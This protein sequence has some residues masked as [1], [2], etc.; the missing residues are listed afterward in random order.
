M[1]LSDFLSYLSTGLSALGIVV[2]SYGALKEAYLFFLRAFAG[3]L[4][5]PWCE[6]GNALV[7]GLE[8]LIA[9]SLVRFAGSLTYSDLGIAGWL[10]ILRIIW[11]IKWTFRT[12][13]SAN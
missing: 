9:A 5:Y 8:F 10:I 3:T 11:S 2:I 4:N 13:I 1:I 12:E 7:V 6:L